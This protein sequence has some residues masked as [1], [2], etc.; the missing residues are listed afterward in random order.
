MEVWIGSAANA[1]DLT[2]QTRY[3]ARR[4]GEALNILQIRF[5]KPIADASTAADGTDYSAE[6][7]VVRETGALWFT[8]DKLLLYADVPKVAT[9]WARSVRQDVSLIGI[10]IEEGTTLAQRTATVETRF[11]PG[12]RLADAVR[13]EDGSGL[14]RFYSITD[15]QED[16]RAGRMR[17]SLV[18]FG[19]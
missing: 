10:Q 4:Q 7:S 11:D 8:G 17:F 16:R 9:R 14:D 12:I 19:V 2:G 6:Y 3:L 13:F 1:G 18:A 5:D 15:S